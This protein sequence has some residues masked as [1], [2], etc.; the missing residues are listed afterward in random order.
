MPRSRLRV[1]RDI[2]AEV[3]WLLPNHG[4]LPYTLIPTGKLRRFV[5]ARMLRKHRNRKVIFCVNS[6]RVGSGYLARLLATA[7]DVV[8][9]HE[10]RP[11]MTGGFLRKVEAAPLHSSYDSRSVKVI[12]VC[13]QL[14]GLS[15]SVTY[16]ETNHMFV[17]AFYDVILDA[18]VNAKVIVL[19][20]NMARTLKSIVELGYFSDSSWHWR[21][22]MQS[23]DSRF[24]AIPAPGSFKELDAV[25]RAIAYLLD[26]EG[27][28]AQLVRQYPDVPIVEC[29]I[30]E[31]A[32]TDGAIKLLRQLGVSANADRLSAISG[33]TNSRH[34]LKGGDFTRISIDTCEERIRAYCR[35]LSAADLRLVAPLVKDIVAVE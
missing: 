1:Y 35:G 10:P 28:A 20:R 6:G 34:D 26:V 17:K 18:F 15:K 2:L 7:D 13:R 9:F 11:R 14:A 33:H 23:Q 19:R 4:N 30:E 3:G 12:G 27:R 29:R 25:D 24:A 21:I 8:A 32:S 5:A 22:W 31:I 16:A